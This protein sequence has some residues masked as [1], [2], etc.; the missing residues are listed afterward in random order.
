MTLKTQNTVFTMG[1]AQQNNAPTQ[2]RTSPFVAA[3]LATA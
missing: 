1:P 2:V 3:Q